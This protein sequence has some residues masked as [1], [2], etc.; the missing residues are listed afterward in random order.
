MS[1]KK[2]D[3]ESGAEIP[4]AAGI[5]VVLILEDGA[6]L[7]R[8]YSTWNGIP[9]RILNGSFDGKEVLSLQIRDVSALPTRPTRPRPEPLPFRAEP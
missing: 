6:P 1:L 3:D 8:H 5:E 4:I 9:R 2:F 7:V